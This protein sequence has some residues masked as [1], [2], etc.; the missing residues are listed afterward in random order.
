[1]SPRGPVLGAN[2][3]SAY[4]PTPSSLWRATVRS[5][6]YSLSVLGHHPRGDRAGAG[7]RVDALGVGTPRTD[8]GILRTAHS[9]TPQRSSRR[10]VCRSASRRESPARRHRDPRLSTNRAVD[11]SR[12]SGNALDARSGGLLQSDLLSRLLRRNPRVGH[13]VV[14]ARL[15]LPPGG[16]RHVNASRAVHDP[17]SCRLDLPSGEM[18]DLR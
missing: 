16:E 15:A 8:N 12:R 3:T 6:H 5:V 13:Q 14:V 1:M 7:D 9:G 10:R 11:I 2:R 18:P 4:T 17:L